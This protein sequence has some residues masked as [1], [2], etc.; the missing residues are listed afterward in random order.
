MYPSAEITAATALGTPRPSRRA[1]WAL[2]LG[3]V[4]TALLLPVLALELLFRLAGPVLPGNY[5]TGIRL[6]RHPVYGH[7]HPPDHQLWI[8]RDEFTT[9]IETNA[10]GQRGKPV[11]IEKPAGTF[12]ILVLGDSFVEAEQVQGCAHVGSMVAGMGV[13]GSRVRN[14]PAEIA[15]E[16]FA[17][18]AYLCDFEASIEEVDAEGRCPCQL[19]RVRRGTRCQQERDQGEPLRGG[20]HPGRSRRVGACYPLGQVSDSS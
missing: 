7:Y 13:P 17:T 5:D 20:P 10:A 18:D 19:G 8:Q 4:G 14:A 6:V 15:T 3:L 16:L 2:R 1:T 11:P 12:R 9:H